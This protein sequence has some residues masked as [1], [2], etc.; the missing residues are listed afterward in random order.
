VSL[1]T[2]SPTDTPDDKTAFSPMELDS[3]QPWTM[4]PTG[5][6]TYAGPTSLVLTEALNNIESLQ[7]L[8]DLSVDRPLLAAIDAIDDLGDGV[9][10]NSDQ[11]PLRQ[12]IGDLNSEAKTPLTADNLYNDGYAG[13]PMPE[14]DGQLDTPNR[15]EELD[16][17]GIPTQGID[18]GPSVFNETPE[19]PI[20]LA[21]Q[22][23]VATLHQQRELD[24]L[25]KALA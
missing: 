21:A 22:L 7:A 17:E 16:P 9:N 12:A 15:L 20:T 18:Q 6:V 4:T 25:A 11:S 8:G 2:I 14:S 3:R 24:A 13:V 10:I 23:R 1:P 19:L 5:G